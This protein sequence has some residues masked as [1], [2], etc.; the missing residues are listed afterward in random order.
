MYFRAVVQSC[1]IEILFT[2]EITEYLAWWIIVVL[3]LLVCSNHDY[4]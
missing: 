1:D 2:L 3:D 4:K